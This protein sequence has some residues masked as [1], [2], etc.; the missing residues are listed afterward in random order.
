MTDESGGSRDDPE[1]V[2]PGEAAAAQERSFWEARR[3]YNELDDDDEA[4]RR[5]RR[6]LSKESRRMNLQVRIHRYAR[7]QDDKGP[8]PGDLRLP[9]L[10]DREDVDDPS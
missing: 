9:P 2:T 8:V 5:E 1:D 3:Q 4:G 10:P 7:G 6:R